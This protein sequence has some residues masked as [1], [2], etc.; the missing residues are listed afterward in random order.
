M[1]GNQKIVVNIVLLG[2]FTYDIEKYI[3]KMR[4]NRSF[5]ELFLVD[6]I[7]EVTDIPSPQK[8]SHYT[9]DDLHELLPE[10]SYPEDIL[11]GIIDEKIDDDINKTNFC[12]P[13]SENV[14]LICV[15][16]MMKFLK[17]HNLSVY[18]YLLAMIYKFVVLKQIKCDFRKIIYFNNHT[19]K[20]CLFAKC[21]NKDDII[22]IL[23]RADICDPCRVELDK[24]Q[25]PTGFYSTIGKKFKRIKKATFYSI[26]DWIE[27]HPIISLV[28]LGLATIFLNLLSNFIFEILRTFLNL[29]GG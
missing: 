19:K 17:G 3:R 1:A 7:R 9:P 22:P 12:Y 14:A 16:D 28:I 26:K 10:P 11:L 24:N 8:T 21:D 13:I 27:S 2:T 4:N 29:V 15:Y 20:N 5:S 18:G 25:K 23:N 6:G